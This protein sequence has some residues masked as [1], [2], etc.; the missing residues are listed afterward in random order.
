M[1][2]KHKNLHALSKEADMTTTHLSNV[3]DQWEREEIVK[4]TRVGREVDMELTKKGEK[5][6]SLLRQ[7]DNLFSG[8][9]NEGQDSADFKNEEAN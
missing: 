3:T 7:F 8:K 1:I 4:K 9:E 2:G 6:V 5:V